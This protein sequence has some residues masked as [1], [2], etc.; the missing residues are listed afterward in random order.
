MPSSSALASD[1]FPAERIDTYFFR[2][3]GNRSF[4]ADHYG[5]NETILRRTVDRLNQLGFVR[6]YKRDKKRIGCLLASLF[7]Y[8]GKILQHYLAAL[9]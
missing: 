6:F 4:I 9:R 7:F 3:F 5:L 8:L 2:G 1:Q